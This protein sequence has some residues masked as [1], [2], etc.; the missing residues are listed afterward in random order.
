MDSFGWTVAAAFVMIAAYGGV[1]FAL[2]VLFLT[3]YL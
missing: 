2:V 3:G 1:L